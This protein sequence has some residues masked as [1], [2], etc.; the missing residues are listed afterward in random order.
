MNN[1]VNPYTK[2]VEDKNQSGTFWN[3]TV[4]VI[5]SLSSVKCTLIWLINAN[6]CEYLH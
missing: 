4:L 6:L 1:K 3:R 2:L 5:L